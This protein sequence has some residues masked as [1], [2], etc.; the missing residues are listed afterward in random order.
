[1]RWWL[2]AWHGARWWLAVRC[3]VRWWWPDDGDDV[4]SPMMVIA[5][6]DLGVAAADCRAG[7]WASRD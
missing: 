7:I 2:A 1:V 4:S 5:G 6:V 3:G